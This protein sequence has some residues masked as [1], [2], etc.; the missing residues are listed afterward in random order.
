MPERMPRLMPLAPFE[1]VAVTG[2][3]YV[4]SRSIAPDPT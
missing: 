3:D 4:W 1:A 2:R